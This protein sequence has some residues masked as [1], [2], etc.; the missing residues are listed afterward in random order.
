MNVFVCTSNLGPMFNITT[1]TKN[2]NIH[3]A[4][5]Y[6]Y[7]EAFGLSLANNGDGSFG[8]LGVSYKDN[9]YNLDP[10]TNYKIT[11]LKIGDTSLSETDISDGNPTISSTST[12]YTSIINADID[13]VWVKSVYKQCTGKELELSYDGSEPIFEPADPIISTI[14]VSITFTKVTK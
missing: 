9:F 3:M 11:A 14:P 6:V 1:G 4:S 7:K 13:K 12:L 5:D 8:C 10:N 2:D